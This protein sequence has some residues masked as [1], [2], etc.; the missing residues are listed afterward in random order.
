M[1]RYEEIVSF[2]KY[3]RELN[4]SPLLTLLT[5]NDTLVYINILDRYRLSASNAKTYSDENG[6]YCMIE[7]TELMRKCR[8]SKN[9]IRDSIYRLE[10]CN[11][12]S[13]EHRQGRATKYYCN[14]ITEILAN[15]QT[16][17]ENDLV[18][19]VQ[20]MTHL[21]QSGFKTD[22]PPSQKLTQSKNN[23][24][25][26]INKN[27]KKS[28]FTDEEIKKIKSLCQL[29]GFTEE[30]IER[31]IHFSSIYNVTVDYVDYASSMY[32]DHFKAY[33]EQMCQHWKEIENGENLE[34]YI[35]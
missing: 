28:H 11:L 4:E 29:W 23:N 21:P 5:G 22:P 10:T 13:T 2:L 12:I 8:L 24:K 16:Q 1:K 25:N 7:I 31:I 9:P 27:F 33:T 3:P 14:D 20:K 15:L 26:N 19:L 18:E 6:I 34:K 30:E 35:N 32:P 17:S